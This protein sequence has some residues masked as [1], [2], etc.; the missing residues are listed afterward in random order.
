MKVF[1]KL[2][3]LQDLEY[4]VLSIYFYS[5]VDTLFFSFFSLFCAQVIIHDQPQSFVFL[6]TSFWCVDLGVVCFCFLFCVHFL[7]IYSWR[8]FMRQR[9]SYSPLA[10]EL[11][12]ESR[13]EKQSTVLPLMLATAPSCSF[14]CSVHH[15][16]SKN[17]DQR[18]QTSQEKITDCQ[19]AS[20]IH[21]TG[22]GK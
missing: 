21:P 11:C 9:W 17:G 22:L 2:C 20:L 12:H 15:K 1:L 19:T 18:S 6:S 16:W 4:Q 13:L 8:I 3:L 10:R 5:A 7:K 14:T